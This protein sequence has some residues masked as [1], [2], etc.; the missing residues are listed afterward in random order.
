MSAAT[1]FLPNVSVYNLTVAG[2]AT[3]TDDA[4][5]GDDLTVSGDISLIGSMSAGGNLTATVGDITASAG[6]IRAT[7]GQV[8]GATVLSDGQLTVASGG[9]SIEG[10]ILQNSGNLTV[11]AGNVQALAVNGGTCDFSGAAEFGASGADTFKVHGAT[12]QSGLQSAFVAQLGAFTDPPT[13]PEMAAL[14]T[15]VNALLTGEINHGFMAP[16]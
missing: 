12:A 5:I 15:A 13:A 8:R 3:V 4:T 2:D 1:F 11:S 16:A 6:A 10:S 7:A 9:M 14:R